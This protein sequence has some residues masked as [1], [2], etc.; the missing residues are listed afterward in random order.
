MAPPNSYIGE[1]DAKRV[2]RFILYDTVLRLWDASTRPSGWHIS[3][4]GPEAGEEGALRYFMKADASQVA[5]VDHEPCGLQ[6]VLR[7]WPAATTCQSDIR[8]LLQR[9]AFNRIAFANL[10]FMGYLTEPRK[11]IVREVGRRMVDGSVCSYTFFRGRESK[12][13]ANWKEILSI[14]STRSTG[15]HGHENLALDEKRF[16]GYAQMLQKLLGQ[17]VELVLML[18]YDSRSGTH[19]RHSP[20]GVLTFQ[21]IFKKTKEWERVVASPVP[22]LTRRSPKE[23]KD[24][25]RFSI[26]SLAKE[27]L[28]SAEISKVMNCP[29]S[30]VAA[31]LANLTRGNYATKKE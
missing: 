2:S 20:M 18:R 17:H 5:F 16:V 14:D 1:T 24:W 8:D 21:K 31:F 13:S 11:E 6:K 27:G 12:I 28:K 30:S 10:D 22:S 4:A 23:M 15:K 29:Q 26:I 25:V 3:L 19:L 9:K 7:S